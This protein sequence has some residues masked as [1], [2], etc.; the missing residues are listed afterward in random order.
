MALEVA[1]GT[2][3]AT[4]A[5]AGNTVSVTGLSF[6]PKVV[7][8]LWSGRTFLSP[9]QSELDHKMGIG[10][11]ISATDR[12]G[13]TTQSDHGN[14]TMSTDKQLFND[15]CIKFLTITGTVESALDFDAWLSDGFR[16]I[17]D[18]A[19][20]TNFLVSYIALGGSDLTDVKSVAVSSA[21]AP[22]SQDTTTVGFQPDCVIFFGPSSS[23]NSSTG[24]SDFSFGVAA[25]A[26][27]LNYV[28]GGTS[29]DAIGTAITLSYCRAG[30]CITEL[31]QDQVDK[32]ANV[33]AWLSNGFTL[34]WDETTSGSSYIALC[35]KGGQYVVGDILSQ[36]NTTNFSE[37]GLAFQPKALIVASHNKTQSTVDT[38]QPHDERTIGFATG[39]AARSYVSIIDKDAAANADVGVAHNTDAVYGNQSTATAI[40]IE[41]LM[42]LVSFDSGGF[43]AVM[44]DADPT[45]EFVWYLAIGDSAVT[46]YTA[47]AALTAGSATLAATATF[48][49]GTKTAT[50]ALT[51]GNATLAA[52]AEFD[53]PV[54]T[55]TSALDTGTATLAASATSAEPTYTGT[56]ALT[57]ANASLAASATH[58]T[59]TYTATSSLTAANATLDAPT[60]FIPPTFTGTSAF[61]VSN[62]TLTASATHTTPVYTGTSSLTA[63]NATLTAAAQ[64]GTV[65]YTGAG[66]LTA[67]NP[68][69]VASATHVAPTYTGTSSL[70]ATNATLNAAATSADPVYTGDGLLVAGNS[71]LAAAAT[72]TSPVYAGIAQL[73][74]GQSTLAASATFA[75]PVYTATAA[76]TT[77]NPQLAATAFFNVSISTATA[78]LVVGATTIAV[79]ATFVPLPTEFRERL[80]INAGPARLVIDSP[81]PTRYVLNAPSTRL[82]IDQEPR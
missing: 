50:A 52:S 55:G 20:G 43:T 9:G 76:L 48:A 59:P 15:A 53:A 79:A 75:V 36:T 58:I 65:I 73:A 18:D 24:W 78:N 6:Q 80:V 81:D 60:I 16:L 67:G 70:T 22:G 11:M 77:A 31:G 68:T 82:V 21:A 62:A 37:T 54:Y 46:S 17:I 61:T 23:L 39:A 41:G 69:L 26:S 10:F 13:H 14:T 33:S 49:P 45:Q 66:T 32:R 1:T 72:F 57:A 34:N 4:T 12:G 56:A 8:F 25:G 7:I 47:T 35:L 64:F 30:H 38:S 40:A 19:S 29:V 5:A 42:D 51:V 71:T 27:P 63:A 74:A 28:T 2:F 3:A 44:D